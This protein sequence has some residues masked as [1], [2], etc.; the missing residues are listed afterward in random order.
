MANSP[1]YESFT[2]YSNAT[3][4]PVTGAAGGFTFNTY[5]DSSGGSPAQPSIVEL[6]GGDYGFIPVFADP[7]KGIT[8]TIQ[9]PAGSSP[10]YFSR[11]MRPED[12]NG[13]EIPAIK[14]DTQ[15][16][17]VVSEGRRKVFT[18]GPNA[19]KEQYFDTDNTTVLQTYDI[20]DSSGNPTSSTPFERV[21]TL[22]IP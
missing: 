4:L 1:I 16:I 14:A 10:A 9:S 13:D 22:P 18:T 15:R 12:W 5:K 7:T 11:Y 8:Y 2:I 19:N 3:G 21:P 17:K 6:G 20:L